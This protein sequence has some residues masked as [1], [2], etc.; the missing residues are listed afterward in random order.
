MHTNLE[1]KT[2]T[3]CKGGGGQKSGV[4]DR[5]PCGS[6]A[7]IS[8]KSG[9]FL[10][11]V[12]AHDSSAAGDCCGEVSRSNRGA[13]LV[14]RSNAGAN[15]ARGRQPQPIKNK[16]DSVDSVDNSVATHRARTRASSQRFDLA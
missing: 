2:K 15:R 8:A 7:R 10:L 9:A 12:D 5:G 1:I 6:T 3:H 11:V 16:V 4:L 14:A 13:F